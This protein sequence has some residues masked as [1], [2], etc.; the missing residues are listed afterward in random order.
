[1][2]PMK[3]C[4]VKA[5]AGRGSE[6][7]PLRHH[8]HRLRMMPRLQLDSTQQSEQIRHELTILRCLQF[9]DCVGQQ[10]DA[11]IRVATLSCAPSNYARAPCS[12]HR[13]PMLRRQLPARFGV[14]SSERDVAQNLPRGRRNPESHG[15]TNLIIEASRD[16]E[17]TIRH[18]AC[19]L[20]LACKRE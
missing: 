17:R 4:A 1:M 7:D 16:G 11:T 18:C 19:A 9:G 10:C 14:L 20:L 5:F 8:F 6:G 13:K 12:H 2:Q 3:F 15:Q